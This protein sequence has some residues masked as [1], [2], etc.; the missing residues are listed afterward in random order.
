MTRKRGTML[1]L[2]TA[3][4][5]AAILGAG[6]NSATA[7]KTADLKVGMVTDIGGLN[8]RG[9]NHLAYVGLQ[10]AEKQLGADIQVAESRSPADYIPNLASFARRG[11]NLV[12]G[13]GYTEIAAMGAVAKKFPKTNFAIV[14]VSNQDLAGKP[15][16][17]LGL[18]F[19]EEQ[20]GY[21]AG[22]LAGL[23]AKR[24][25]G[26]DVVSSVAGEKQPPVDRFIAGYQAGAKKADPG[27]KTIN[28]YSQDFSDQAKCKA[29]A[30][31]QIA[32][33]SAAVFQVAGGCG[34]GALD[35]AKERNVW[36]IGVDADQSNLGPHIL[37][38]ATKKVDRAVFLAIQ[39]LKA[40]KF[41]GGDAVYGLAQGGVGLGKISPKVPKSEVAAVK[42]IQAQIV[43]GKIT[44]P[45]VFKG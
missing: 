24:K 5:V 4:L 23:E 28:G 22:Y 26:P 38:S 7:T 9:F 29:I 42:R 15:K 45:K 36:G 8:D 41:R 1:A 21:L 31:N 32:A 40:G 16:N 30:L 27:I 39:S 34:L 18:L 17:V 19:H 44:I 20:V 14:D 6:V 13:V 2:T 43:A 12:V 3:A 25:P 10:Q 37:T 33:G 35:A 11:Y